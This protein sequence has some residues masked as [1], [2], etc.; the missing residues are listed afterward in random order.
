MS[1]GHH[2]DFTR[3]AHRRGPSD[4]N[5]AA[6][7][8]VFFLLMGV[9]PFV[10]GRGPIRP[11]WLVASLVFL[12]ICWLKPSLLKP[13]NWVWTRIGLL[14][15]KVVNPIVTGLL[16]YLFFTPVAVILRMMGKDL[17]EIARDDK[18]ESY[19]ITRGSEVAESEMSNQF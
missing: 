9:W 16:F 2:E 3:E 18:A 13:A 8:S 11:A 19:W 7:F 5:F 4:R 10:R 6:V 12:L 15:G 1:Q 14:L 17:L